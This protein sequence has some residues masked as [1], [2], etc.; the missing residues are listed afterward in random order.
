MRLSGG[1]RQMKSHRKLSYDICNVLPRSVELITVPSH[2]IIV[3][4][5]FR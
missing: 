2:L 4:V 1:K 3:S 5:L